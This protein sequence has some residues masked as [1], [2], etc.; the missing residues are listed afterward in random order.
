MARGTDIQSG[1]SITLPGPL[2]QQPSRYGR[3]EAHLTARFTV[4]DRTNGNLRAQRTP[5]VMYANPREHLA[6]RLLQGYAAAGS[7]FAQKR[8]DPGERFLDRVEVRQV[9]WQG[10]TTYYLRIMVE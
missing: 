8:L 10:D 3:Y 7:D 9:W 6:Y 5:S 4:A 2:G 1:G